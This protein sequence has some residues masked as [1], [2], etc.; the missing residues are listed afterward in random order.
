MNTEELLGKKVM[1][2]H[3][4]EVGTVR[5]TRALD[6]DGTPAVYV[7]IASGDKRPSINRVWNVK[8]IEEVEG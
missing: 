3:S 6:L 4:G 7:E 1:H 8:E 5:G 2:I